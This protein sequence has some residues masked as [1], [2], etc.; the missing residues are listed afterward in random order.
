MHSRGIFLLV[1]LS[2]IVYWILSLRILVTIN[3]ETGALS[4]RRLVAAYAW[5][6]ARCSCRSIPVEA[7]YPKYGQLQAKVTTT[8]S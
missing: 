3:G 1:C 7:R 5:Y 4:L 2:F 6:T 8:I